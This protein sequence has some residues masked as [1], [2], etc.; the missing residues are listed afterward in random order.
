MQHFSEIHVW[1]SEPNERS[2]VR[3]YSIFITSGKFSDNSLCLFLH[4]NFRKPRMKT[5]VSVTASCMSIRTCILFR[6][7]LAFS[8]YGESFFMSIKHSPF[9]SIINLISQ[10]HQRS[11]SCFLFNPTRIIIIIKDSYITYREL[12]EFIKSFH[13]ARN[14]ETIIQSHV[15]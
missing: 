5:L 15:K 10:I 9:D 12:N 13:E 2:I 6:V 4:K 1:K 7:P 3:N 11:S 14:I 8:L